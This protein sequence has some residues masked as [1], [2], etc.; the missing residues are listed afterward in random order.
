M[1]SNKDKNRLIEN[2]KGNFVIDFQAYEDSKYDEEEKF[3]R[4]FGRE[5]NAD[6]IKVHKEMLEKIKIIH[7]IGNEF[8][9]QA[10]V[11]PINYHPNC[12]IQI[13]IGKEKE[14][15]A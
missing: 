11:D 8:L 14:E 7:Q 12:F 6:H 3:K 5:W 10:G 9:E 13:V 15:A 4:Q 1:A 2:L